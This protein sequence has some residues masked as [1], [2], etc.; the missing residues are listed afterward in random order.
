MTD[1]PDTAK[2]SPAAVNDIPPSAEDLK[3]IEN[4]VV[5]DNKEEPRPFKSLYAGPGAASRVLV[6]FIRHFFCGACKNYV[7][8]LSESASPEKLKPIDTSI[9]FVGCGDAS[10]IDGYV[11][12][13]GC[14]HPVYSNPGVDLF[15][16][17]GM[18]KTMNP[19]T[20]KDYVPESQVR[21]AVGGLSNA[22]GKWM[23]GA[24]VTKGG[25]I[26]QQG[27]ELLFE[28]EGDNRRVTWCHR[29]RDGKDHTDKNDILKVIGLG[30]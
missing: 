12:D 5:Y 15:D 16:A 4:F 26:A 6:I 1:A 24:A 13:T 25:S 3:A 10:L 8:F 9:V 20:P 21:L 28:G 22:F 2:P 11:E 30:G 7:K 27:A 14:P 19:G 29:M 17:L 18:V 23:G